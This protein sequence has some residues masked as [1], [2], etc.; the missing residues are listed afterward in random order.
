MYFLDLARH[1]LATAIEKYK[2]DTHQGSCG[3]SFQNNCRFGFLIV[4]VLKS[5]LIPEKNLW[6]AHIFFQ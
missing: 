5:C 4:L 1:D 6:T 2:I 3:M